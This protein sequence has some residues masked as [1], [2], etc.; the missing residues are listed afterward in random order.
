[1]TS[2]VSG[3]PK[4]ANISPSLRLHPKTNP[5]PN[6]LSVLLNN[7]KIRGADKGDDLGCVSFLIF[8]LHTREALSYV[9]YS[10]DLQDSDDRVPEPRQP[11]ALS[12][13]SRS[14]IELG[15]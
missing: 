13:I 8:L 15:R 9:S 7:H 6:L 1:M 14:C 3:L 2:F 12:K 10:R 4:S 5:G 11:Q